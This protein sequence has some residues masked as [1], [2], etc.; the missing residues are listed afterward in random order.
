MATGA[1]VVLA[2]VLLI[3]I[4]LALG[5][6]PLKVPRQ[7]SFEGIEDDAVVRAYD[8]ISRWPQF[9]ALRWLVVQELKR[10][11]PSG[12]LVDAGCGPGYLI[13]TIARSLP[14]L[15]IIGVDIS[16]E[17][18]ERAKQNLSSLGLADKVIFRQGD[19]QA[20]P[21]EDN[22]VDFLVSTLSLHHWSDPKRA[23][24]E[25][26]RVLEP[27]GQ[28]LIFDIRRDSRYL[29][30]WLIQF[31]QRFVIPSVMRKANEPTGSLLAGYTT[32]ELKAMLSETPFARWQVKP[33]FGWAFAWGKKDN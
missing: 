11:H 17:M 4:V 1:W 16:E 31:A 21:F 7:V 29:F 3:V 10:H 28:F 13:A 14:H 8:R 22:S 18:A 26:H 6:R 2:I 24:Q 33:G 32:A 30:Y 9:K 19:I 27:D 15:S 20:L 5:L 12:I 25:I 23:L